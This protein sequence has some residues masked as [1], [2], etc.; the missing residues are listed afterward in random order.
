MASFAPEPVHPPRLAAALAGFAAL[1]ACA[2]AACR[3]GDAL[4]PRAEMALRQKL[5]AAYPAVKEWS[6]S[7]L[8]R[9]LQESASLERLRLRHPTVYV[10]RVGAQSAVWV[11]GA[12][13]A[14]LPRGA[15]LWFSV[16]GYGP[17]LIAS[18]LIPSGTALE[19][20]EASPGE[21]DWV[22][23]G[24]RLL[25]DPTSLGGMRAATM[26]RRGEPI[27]ASA[28][29]AM[30]PVVRGEQVSARFSS[31]G[32]VITAPVEALSDGAIG[33]PVTV[34]NQESGEVFTATVVGKAEVAVGE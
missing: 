9:Q 30:P 18:Q 25:S 4:V 5:V 32:V 10:T 22:A 29:Q 28:I 21:A 8:P 24:C 17:A 23:A 20:S 6:V 31:H 27:C 26:I 15:L 1:A 14:A 2:N 12:P 11:G 34:R 13:T 3:A 16:S 7:L 33:A 19:P